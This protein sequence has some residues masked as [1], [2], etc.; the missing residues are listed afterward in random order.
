MTKVLIID[1]D[2]LMQTLYQRVFSLEGFEVAIAISGAAGLE[3]AVSFQPDI[4]LL[5]MMMPVVNGLEVL[6]KLKA[7]P[8]VKQIPVI[9]CSNYSE[10]SMLNRAI[11]LGA[12][13][14]LV[15]SDSDPDEVLRIVRGVLAGNSTPEKSAAS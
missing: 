4:I 7:D 3:K 8:A 1:D 5:D 6:G 2:E 14:Y 13:H 10:Q 12:S 11:A 9:V 15:K